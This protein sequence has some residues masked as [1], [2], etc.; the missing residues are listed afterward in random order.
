MRLAYKA[1][2]PGFV[3]RGV[4]FK[5]IGEVNVTS[6]A[7]CRRNGWHCA[8]NPADCLSYYPD[9]DKSWYCLVGIG[10]DV[11]EDDHDSK[12]SC[13]EL[14]IL[15]ELSLPDYFL[16]ILIYMAKH[17]SVPCSIT[18]NGRGDTGRKGYAVVRG[19]R[20]YAKGKLGDILAM[21]R[22][23]NGEIVQIAVHVVDGESVPENTYVDI[24]GKEE[25]TSGQSRTP[26]PT[27]KGGHKR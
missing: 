16:H 7:N 12:I 3:C 2:S 15:R 1:F 13:T 10:G 18:Q 20:P 8:E 22:E 25:F 4:A 14:T 6:A 23:E 24:D 5:P 26:V 19:L 27:R 9:I 17:P 21:A 11:D